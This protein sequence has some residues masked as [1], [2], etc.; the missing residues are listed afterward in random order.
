MRKTYLLAQ[1]EMGRRVMGVFP[2]QY[3]REILW[4]MHMTPAEIWDPPVEI[5]RANAHLQPY[6]CSVVKSGLE[7]ILAGKCDFLDGF[8][9]PHTCDSIQNLASIINDYLTLK[10]PCYFFYHPK[11]PYKPSSRSYYIQQ[12]KTLISTLEREM[13]PLDP[14]EF[15]ASVARGRTLGALISS[16][17]G[18]RRNGALTA[19][20][21]D[22]YRTMRQG[23]YLHPDDFIPLL[24]SFRVQN[25]GQHAPG[26]A[27][28]LSGVLPNPPE[29]LYLLD[30]LGVR[31]ADD[32]LLNCGRRWM[33][34]GTQAQD[35]FEALADGYFSL[36][37]CTTK[38]SPI[39]ERIRFLTRM[40]EKSGAKGVIFY[41]VKFCEPEL[42]DVPI[43]SEA[44]KQL[45]VPVLMLDVDINQGLT[46]QLTTRVEAFVEMMR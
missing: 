45:G 23:E 2:A 7:L 35:P 39:A 25:G 43:I 10:K 5:S 34:E 16:I 33:V 14:R 31:I 18:Q 41:M 36:P 40:I 9:F 37:P 19:S 1:K 22:F 27:V 44:I 17:Y 30:D 46:G 21:A 11:A 32:D 28:I 26:P 20:N 38:E 42:F 24:E 13:G 29:I 8:L 6:I 3:P 12:L 4:A 15:K